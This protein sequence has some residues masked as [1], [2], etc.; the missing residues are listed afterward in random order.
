MSAARSGS[1]ISQFDEVLL[2]AR[3]GEGWAL[4]A[5][6]HGYA[7]PVGGYVRARTSAEVDDLV[8]EIF[9]SAFTSLD[10]FTGGEA[11]FRGWLFTIAARRVVDDLRRRGRR[12]QTS[13]YDPADDPRT[14]ASAEDRSL[15][16]MGEQ[17]ARGVLDQLVP[18]QREVLL[19]RVLGDLTV[20]QVAAQLGKTPGAVK[21]LQRRGLAAAAKIVQA[22][23]VPL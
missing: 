14:E 7:G 19:L 15:D 9:T 2:A 5:L 3:L 23:G 10:R 22:Q 21:Q 6:F 17:W 11:D 1:G 13:F 12:V 20:E 18:D 8:S 16:R 4:T